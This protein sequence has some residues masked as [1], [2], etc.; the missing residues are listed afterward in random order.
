MPVNMTSDMDW[1]AATPYVNAGA[2]NMKYKGTLRGVIVDRRG[3]IVALALNTD[4]GR[5]LVRVPAELRQIARGHIGGSDR[6]ASLI[7][8]SNIEVNGMMEAQRLGFLSPYSQRIAANTIKV[9]GKNAGAIS[10][11]ML[12]P[13]QRRGLL[14]FDIGG[15]IM[16]ND[17]MKDENAS[18]MGY[19]VYNASD[20]GMMNNG[21]MG[22]G[23]MNNGSMSTNT[24]MNTTMSQTATGR[25]MIVTADNQMLPVV[26]KNGKVWA[27]MADG[28][29][30]ELMKVN[31]KFVVPA[32]MMGARMM[33][34]M[35][36]GARMEMDTVNGQMM[37][38]MADGTMAPVTLHTP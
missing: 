3:D 33:M 11:Q 38:M 1:L 26:K 36:D 24:T 32:G 4:N 13:A 8:G 22:G 34:V 2:T 15:D 17:N 25:V 29:M 30:S 12:A 27:M 7:K 35:S 31:G 9:N 19:R 37:V 23:M 21:M 20:N 6:V 18:M 10:I 5:A 16:D 28:S 14:G